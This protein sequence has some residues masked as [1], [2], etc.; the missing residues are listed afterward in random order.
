MKIEQVNRTKVVIKKNIL[1]KNRTKIGLICIYIL[2]NFEFH[3]INFK[4]K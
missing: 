1:K 3:Q 2:F 4:N